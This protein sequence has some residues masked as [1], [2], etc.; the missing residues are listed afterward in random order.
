MQTHKMWEL[1]L[2]ILINPWNSNNNNNN[3]LNPKGTTYV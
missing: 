3:K 1:K 2:I